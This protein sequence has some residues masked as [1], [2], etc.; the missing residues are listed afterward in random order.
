MKCNINIGPHLKLMKI[1]STSYISSAEMLRQ[2]SS[3]FQ[4]L[5]ALVC[6]WVGLELELLFLG[7]LFFAKGQGLR[8]GLMKDG[9]G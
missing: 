3:F 6:F 2:F 4:L 7:W 5:M 8:L 9:D 1:F